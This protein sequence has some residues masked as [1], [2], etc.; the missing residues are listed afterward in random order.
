MLPA[1]VMFGNRAYD[2][3][4]IPTLRWFGGRWVNHD[5]AAGRQL[6]AGD[7]PQGRGLAAAGWAQE[8][9][10]L[11]PLGGEVEVLD[12][13]HLAEPLL[14]TGQLEERHERM[15]SMAQCAPPT[16]MRV[17]EPR[18]SIAMAII[19]SQVTPKLI[20]ETAAGS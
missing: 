3:N 11:T 7:H 5:R 4:T 10:E 16:W 9:D 14:D 17:R 13:G 20:N 15:P 8:R 2:W 19:A 1:T 18:P 6:E 12:C